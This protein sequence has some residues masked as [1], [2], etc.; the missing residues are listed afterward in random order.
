M[1]IF[2]LCLGFVAL[3]FAAWGLIYLLSAYVLPPKTVA[4]RLKK[5]DV[6]GQETVTGKKIKKYRLTFLIDEKTKSYT[7]SAEAFRLA[8]ETENGLLTT[9]GAR[10]L[11]F[12]KK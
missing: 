4:A 3:P 1:D 8:R 12:E 7:V 6:I 9:R 11:S 2:F 10:F 5:K